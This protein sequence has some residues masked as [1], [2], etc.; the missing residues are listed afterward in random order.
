MI[1]AQKPT[2][3]NKPDDAEHTASGARKSK[4][5]LITAGCVVL[6]VL[7]LLAGVLYGYYRSKVALLDYDDGTIS[8]D[9]SFAADDE[10]MQA[11]NAAMEQATQD[12][13]E[14]DAIAAE[15]DVLGDKNVF[16]ILLIGTDERTKNFSTNARGDSCMLFSINKETMVV[17]L[18][19]FERG[20]G[21]PIL[22]GQYKGQWD[23]LTHT[24]RYGG[25]DLMMREIEECFKIKIDYYVR[26]NFNTFEQLINAAGG[27]D[28]ELTA[29]EVQGLNGEVSTNARTHAT[30]HVGMNH[31]DGYDALQYSRLR[32]IDSDWKRIGRQRNVM[33]SLIEK[34][35]TLNILELNNLLDTVLPLLRTNLT[36][37]EITGLLLALAPKAGQVTVQQMTIPASGTYGSMKGMGGRSLFAVDF[38]ANAKLLQETLYGVSE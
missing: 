35:K 9:G 11:D 30:V 24:F 22:D 2:K 17:H 32:Y 1:Q 20:M 5:V 21:V 10:D 25:A 12:L 27:V 29:A 13:E 19:S 26:A 23:W 37:S 31:L 15:G 34:C 33:Q 14:M 36:E 3:T 28:I 16:N 18:V 38:D 6:A 4:R 8:E 7:L